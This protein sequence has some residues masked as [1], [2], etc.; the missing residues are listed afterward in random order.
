MVNLITYLHKIII[1]ADNLILPLKEANF[2]KVG[3]FYQ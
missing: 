1:I 2:Y 3:F